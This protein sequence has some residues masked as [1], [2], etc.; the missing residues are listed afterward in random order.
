MK[1]VTLDPKLDERLRDAERRF[2]EVN[3]ALASPDVLS[4]PEKLRELAQERSHLEPIVT[5]GGRLRAAVAEYGGAAELLEESDDADMRA[6][7][8][9]EVSSLD[10]SIEALT[11]EL[12]ELL[13]PQDPLGDR[14]AVVEIR[15][16]T[17]GDE[18]GLF[19]SDL[20]EMYRRLAELHGWSIEIGRA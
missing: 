17:G 19:A 13:V 6:L 11:A 14:A 20:M 18:A 15:A 8:E 2:A 5:I 1:T 4:A 12:R 9:I 10:E 16:G 3:E 7:A